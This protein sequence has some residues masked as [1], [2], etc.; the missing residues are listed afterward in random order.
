MQVFPE[1]ADIQT[2]KS[3]TALHKPAEQ[4][5]AA[6]VCEY[7]NRILLDLTK[8]L[9]ETDE[10]KVTALKEDI[11]AARRI[12]VSGAGRSLLM[13]KAFAMR[14]MHLGFTVFAV[15]EVVTPAIREGDLLLIG[16]ASGETATL[17]VVARKAKEAGAKLGVLTIFEDSALARAADTVVKIPAVTNQVTG[18]G[19]SRQPG[20][21]S[22]E[23][24]LL[25]L[26]DALTARLADELSLRVTEPLQ[27]HA[28]LE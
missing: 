20:G 15:G 14:L 27:N 6:E 16:S 8:I 1:T 17:R 26:L 4:I 19:A 21:S 25:I 11:R 5:K 22:F 10:T 28:N 13:M 7:A 3:H 2:E 18:G 9:R 24:S 23:Q 12:F